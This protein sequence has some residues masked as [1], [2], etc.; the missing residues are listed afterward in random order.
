MGKHL[1]IEEKLNAENELLKNR[2]KIKQLREEIN[3]LKYRNDR[4]IYYLHNKKYGR[5][6][7]KGLC[8]AQCKMYKMYGKKK[9]D[10]TPE[11]LREYNK[12]KQ[13]EHRSKL[14]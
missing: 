2:E 11:E 5:S 12:I 14:F 1:T 7:H 9:S 8:Y 13:I 6:K 3:K 10:L 4:L